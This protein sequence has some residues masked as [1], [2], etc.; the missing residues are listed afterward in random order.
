[1]TR[2]SSNGS[3]DSSDDDRRRIGEEIA[4]RLRRNGVELTG[5][6]Q[7]DEL[8]DLEEAVENFERMVERAGGDLMVDEPVTGGKPIA[9][10]E[11]DFVLPARKASEPVAAYVKRLNDAA[12]RVAEK[13]KT[14]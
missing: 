12:S 11:P 3:S 1:V 7:S 2:V 14:S 4:L 9:P 10:D 5:K 13:G 8:A 6:E